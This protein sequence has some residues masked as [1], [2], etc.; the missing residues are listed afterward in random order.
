MPT[1]TDREL[2]LLSA[3]VAVVATLLWCLAFGRLDFDM[4]DEGYLWYGAQRMLHGE[5][6]I[7]DFHSYD[8]GRYAL[9]AAYFAAIGDSGIMSLRLASY[10][11]ICSTV[12][13]TVFTV[14]HGAR[15][16]TGRQPVRVALLATSTALLTLLWIYPY[17]KGFDRLASA[18][19]VLAVY[20]LLLRRSR[21]AWFLAGAGVGIAAIIGRN[22]GLYGAA[23]SVLAFLLLAFTTRPGQGRPGIGEV[24]A[25]IAGVLAGYA[26]MAVAFLAVD[27]LWDALVQGI[28]EMRRLGRTNLPLE[29]PW[30]WIARQHWPDLKVMMLR[31]A[32]G[33]GFVALLAVPIAGL[34]FVL[35]R[36]ALPPQ[37]AAF[38]SACCVA[39]PYAHYAYSRADVMHL[40]LSFHPLSIALLTLPF[41]GRTAGR[42]VLAALLACFS[43]LAL[44]EAPVVS[45]WANRYDHWETIDVQGEPLVV[46]SQ[47]AAEYRERTAAVDRYDPG[48]RSFFAMPN[49]PGLHAIHDSRIATY[50]IYIGFPMSAEAEDAEIERLAR[51]APR[52]ILLSNHALDGD[53]ALRLRSLRPRLYRW[54]EAHYRRLPDDGPPRKDP[55]QVYLRLQPA[56]A[57][58]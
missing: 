38:A 10:A 58:R 12:G 44:F 1:L 15:R 41:A 5:L 21:A 45:R 27:G 37:H 26:P 6:P 39:L 22:H 4:A 20:A 53:E 35:R 29:V 17:Y 32:P 47:V 57:S 14:A 33:I 40:A 25:W 49:L 56:D 16:Q 42:I 46:R 48:G 54:I 7:R 36:R 23:A 13:L 30:P 8:P 52:L 19:L 3:A 55:L 34:A 18:L 2:A 51:A 11:V 50:H 28:V 9:V 24:A 43:V 31:A